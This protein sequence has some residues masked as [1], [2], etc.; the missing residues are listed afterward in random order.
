MKTCFRDIL[1]T[2]IYFK[3]MSQNIFKDHFTK[4]YS[5]TQIVSGGI[6]F[7]DKSLVSALYCRFMNLC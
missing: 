2:C 1:Y 7:K 3:I 4:S 6:S 5:V